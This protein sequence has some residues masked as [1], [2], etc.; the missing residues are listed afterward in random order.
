MSHN[1][2]SATVQSLTSKT[3]APDSWS[4]ICPHLPVVSIHRAPTL[5][6]PP[7]RE[8]Q[9]D[10]MRVIVCKKLGDP[11]LD[12]SSGVLALEDRPSPAIKPGHVRIQVAAASLNFPDALQV[13][14]RTTCK[15]TGPL[16]LDAMPC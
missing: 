15:H 2:D 3:L 12:L 10:T 9:R 16:K 5:Y 6:T 7:A 8:Q 4:F 14:V 13:Q 11:T 1:R